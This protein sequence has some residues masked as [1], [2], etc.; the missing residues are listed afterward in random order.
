MNRCTITV[1]VMLVKTM[2]Y[3]CLFEKLL[4]IYSLLRFIS[5]CTIQQMIICNNITERRGI[6]SNISVWSI[7]FASER[8]DPY[9]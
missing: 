6:S 4:T 5:L 2:N 1:I 7:V 3:S 9:R 8:Q